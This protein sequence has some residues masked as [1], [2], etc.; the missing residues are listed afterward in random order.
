M[1]QNF[2]IRDELQHPFEAAFEAF[3]GRRRRKCRL[4]LQI[5]DAS[6]GAKRAQCVSYNH[7]PAVTGTILEDGVIRSF[8]CDSSLTLPLN[9]TTVDFVIVRFWNGA[10]PAVARIRPLIDEA[11]RVASPDAEILFLYHAMQAS[12]KVSPQSIWHTVSNRTIEILLALTTLRYRL[13]KRAL[14]RAG[15]TQF[16]WFAPE[17]DADGAPTTIHSVKP[18]SF[19]PDG[20]SWREW[21]RVR[22][23]P[24]LIARSSRTALPLTHFEYAVEETKKILPV[25]TQ[26]L[27]TEKILISH[28]EKIVGLLRGPAEGVVVRL[29]F[30][31]LATNN[32]RQN[33][34]A[35][36]RLKNLPFVNRLAPRPLLEFDK[37]DSYFSTE[38]FVSGK[39]LK[40]FPQS[41]D[42]LEFVEELLHA[43]NDPGDLKTETL[44]G[45]AYEYRVERPL[46]K[47][48][49][50]ASS[51]SNS[52]LVR[53]IL[54]EK[55][56]GLS[57]PVGLTHGDLSTNNLLIQ[58]GRNCGVIDWDEGS[59]LGVPVL[60]AICHLISRQFRRKPGF[61]S[62]LSQLISRQWPVKEELEFLDRCYQYFR[63]DPAHH[64]G[65][66]MLHWLRSVS[67]QSDL[68]YAKE[69][70]FVDRHID[71][72]VEFIIQYSEKNSGHPAEL[73]T[74]R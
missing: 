39:P 60:D 49:S 21:L 28:K 72:V 34:K 16:E 71:K 26:N 54:S 7:L 32:C 65:F 41:T 9:K 15:L 33:I 44:E 30:S 18:D 61:S 29:P 35:L 19:R 74:P 56:H 22:S 23:L 17:Y 58:N 36:N 4:Y 11:I 13:L 3:V 43:M 67:I 52:S 66:V 27:K 69:A 12:P 55:L 25:P 38:S 5:G 10:M 63:V 62:A 50:V 42:S 45:S 70:I 59:L 73:A 24:T 1:R 47:L 2:L 68:I 8:N 14:R 53:K 51:S 57:I 64:F 6:I 40:Q 37:D 31:E 48:L 46:E 20:V